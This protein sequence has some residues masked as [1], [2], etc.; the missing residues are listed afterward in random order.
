[1]RL[2]LV[3]FDKW[4]KDSS[5]MK[6]AEAFEKLRRM[7]IFSELDG[8]IKFN[9]IFKDNMRLALTGG[10]DHSSFGM[11][12]VTA[13]KNAVSVAFL[14]SH[15][16]NQWETILHFMVGT[17]ISKQPGAGVISLLTYGN[18]MKSGRITTTGF[19]FLLQDTNAQIW[20]LLLH[21]LRITEKMAMDPVEVIHFLF[22]LGNLELGQDYSTEGLTDTQLQMLEDLRDY[23]IVYQR[24][25]SSRRFYPTRLAT[26]LTN[27]SHLRSAAASLTSALP[28]GPSE[29]GFVIL[30]TNYKLYAYTSS[31]LQIAVLNLFV[32][33]N[34]RFP[35][36]VTGHI[37]REAVRKA[38]E[39]GITADQII[40]YLSSHAHPQMRKN[41]PLLPPTVV[42]QIRLWE[43]EKNRLKATEGYLFKEFKTTAD[44][45][46][47]LK[48]ARELGVVIYENHVKRMF[49]TSAGGAQPVVEFVK[50]KLTNG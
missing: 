39:N 43:L 26:T 13:D 47:I 2:S 41:T 16:M 8:Y 25:S 20:T 9:Q 29:N 34:Q 22:M 7:H 44:F 45:E 40:L 24:K 19:Q 37:N 23:G 1:M 15:C 5:K 48:Y 14:D 35:N 3:D 33:L 21:Y 31:P 42:D 17:A 12:C 46:M 18:L 36:L 50:R 10:G 6:Q 49:F 38:L 4:T 27:D 30:E 11:P 28:A 32:G